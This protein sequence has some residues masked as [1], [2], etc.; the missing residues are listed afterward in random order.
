MNSRLSVSHLAAVAGSP[1]YAGLHAVNSLGHPRLMGFYEREALWGQTG[2]RSLPAPGSRGRPV[3]LV[4]EDVSSVLDVGCGE[5]GSSPM[6]SHRTLKS[7]ASI[8]SRAALRHVRRRTTV[9]PRS[10]SSPL[11]KT[12]SISSWRQMCW[13]TSL[14]PTMQ[15]LCQSSHGWRG[16]TA[17]RR[18]VR[19]GP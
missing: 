9:A 1:R 18:A 2:T 6:H 4:P 16:Q 3:P 15:E 12:R 13:N 8:P 14:T 5:P 19:G 17:N 10:Q 7:S 11:V